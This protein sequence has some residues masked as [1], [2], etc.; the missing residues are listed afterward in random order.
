MCVPQRG[1]WHQAEQDGARPG[2][3]IQMAVWTKPR[4]QGGRPTATTIMAI[5]TALPR[6]LMAAA[7]LAMTWLPDGCHSTSLSSTTTEV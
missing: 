7:A 5:A 4:G 3:R 2:A 6:L 1:K